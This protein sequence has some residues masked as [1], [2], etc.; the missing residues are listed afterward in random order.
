[1]DKMYKNAVIILKEVQL[2]YN[3]QFKHKLEVFHD[4]NMT[5]YEKETIGIWGPS[6]SGKTSLFNLIMQKILP[7]SGTVISHHNIQMI[8][9]FPMLTPTLTCEEYLEIDLNYNDNESNFSP[10]EL[11]DTVGLRKQKN[12]LIKFLSGGEKQ[13]LAIISAIACGAEVILADEPFGRI[14]LKTAQIVSDYLFEV[15]KLYDLTLL[16]ASHYWKHF[17]KMDCIFKIEK[18][19]LKEI[20]PDF[21]MPKI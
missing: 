1:M 9:Q 5:I 13:R 7:T 10:V 19:T 6:G 16:L 18:N 4:L 3:L 12:Y 20:K 8:Y 17:E 11:L 2:T 21:F 14:D 15:V